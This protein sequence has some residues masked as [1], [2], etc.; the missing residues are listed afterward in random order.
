[1]KK[2]G[3]ILAFDV[4]PETQERTALG[5]L[6]PGE[7]V[8]IELSLRPSDRIGGHF[9][10]GHVDGTGKIIRKEEDGRYAKLW[11]EARPEITKMMVSKGS[12]AIDGVSMT[13]VDVE[14][15]KF[16]VCVIPHTLKVTTL[17]KK[18]PGDSVNLETDM[19]GKYVRKFLE[20]ERNGWRNDRSGFPVISKKKNKNTK[21]A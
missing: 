7:E 4:M 14:K 12:V 16:S 11:I 21:T 17:G 3:G 1:V 9:V 20:N 5:S 19:L 13:V 6:R 18:G 15:D 10:L 8:N 2:A